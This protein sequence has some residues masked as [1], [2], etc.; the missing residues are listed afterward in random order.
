MGV[1]GV[2]PS[3]AKFLSIALYLAI[4]SYHIPELYTLFLLFVSLPLVR[5]TILIS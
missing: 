5:V 1:S 3:T 2:S 4:H